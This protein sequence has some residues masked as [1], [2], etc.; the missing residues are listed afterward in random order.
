[1][2]IGFVG[3]GSM[4]AALAGKWVGKHELFV[5][6]R[7]RDKAHTLAETLGQGTKAG[8]EAE[9]VRFGDVV[10]LATRH[11]NVFEAIEAAGGAN[12]FAG[13][14]VIDINNAVSSDTFLM[15]PM[16]GQSLAQA[17]QGRL[18]AARIVKAFN[19]CQAKVWAMPEPVFDGRR[20]QVLMCGDNAG[21]KAM[22]GTLIRDVGCEP[23]DLGGLQYAAHIEHAGAIVIKLLFGGRDPLTVLNL[24]D[25]AG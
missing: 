19:M 18:P 17:I 8:S 21:A 4:A 14:T 20:L 25:A 1:M 22:V 7:N 10:V 6:G 12:A 16:G 24:V 5:G 11:E 3:Y 23:L 13:K 9:A 15:Q 2:K